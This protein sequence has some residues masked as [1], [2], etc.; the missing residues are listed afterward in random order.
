MLKLLE[1]GRQTDYWLVKHKPN[2]DPL[3]M[4]GMDNPYSSLG[5]LYTPPPPGIGYGNN[6]QHW[7]ETGFPMGGGGYWR[8]VPAPMTEGG[9]SR[10]VALLNC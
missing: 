4:T 8:R 5:Q 9:L 7:R 2:F 10:L 3:L 6:L 1:E